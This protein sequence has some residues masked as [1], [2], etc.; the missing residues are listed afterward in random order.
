[1]DDLD[2]S[3]QGKLDADTEFQ[4]SIASL[5][6]EEKDQKISEKRSEVTKLLWK[7]TQENLKKQAEIA[8][9]QRKRA[10]KAE[11][12]RKSGKSGDE[13]N[14]APKSELSIA[15]L[16]AFTN[17]K[18]HEEDVPEVLKAAK[19][20]GKEPRE[21]LKD[22]IVQAILERENAR[23]R[24]ADA[25]N[26]GTARRSNRQMS[27]DEILSDVKKGGELPDPGSREA[28]ELYWARRGGKP[29]K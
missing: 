13:P 3:V 22:P 9:N 29:S 14:D 8:E 5:S 2:A 12:E 27:G 20:L 26:T 15:D 25:T 18:V 16:Y 17:A 19:L 21:A 23:R 24:T 1:M 28:E 10:E 7:E 6:D 4:N 11:K